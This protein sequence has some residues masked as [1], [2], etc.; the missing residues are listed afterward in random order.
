M[1]KKEKKTN[2]IWIM[3]DQLRADMLGCNKDPNV[4]TPNIDALAGEGVNFCRAVSTYTLCCP[5]RGTMLTGIYPNRCTLG[6]EYRMPANQKTIADVLSK[7]GYHTAWFG[8]WH[9]DGAHEHM[10]RIALAGRVFLLDG[11]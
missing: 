10:G 7:E 4:H 9:L 6:H 2:L 1:S 3:A 11:V 8:K 5:A